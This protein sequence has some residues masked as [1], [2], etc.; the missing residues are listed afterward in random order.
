LTADRTSLSGV[1]TTLIYFSIS[2]YDCVGLKRGARAMHF[3]CG[4]RPSGCR[5]SSALPPSISPSARPWTTRQLAHQWPMD[6]RRRACFN[7]LAEDVPLIRTRLEIERTCRPLLRS[8]VGLKKRRRICRLKSI[9]D[10]RVGS[11][12]TRVLIAAET[13]NC[14][15]AAQQ[16]RTN[17][18]SASRA[19][20]C[21][22]HGHCFN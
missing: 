19:I 13:D 1:P 3:W 12:Q 9:N 22:I 5:S 17:R 15:P 8:K 6:R 11:K 20:T 18:A 4:A 10:L 16:A 2:G 14:K 7:H 21:V